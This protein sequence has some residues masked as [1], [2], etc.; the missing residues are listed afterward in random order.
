MFNN[1]F[2]KSSPLNISYNVD[3]NKMEIKGKA[4]RKN[5]ISGMITYDNLILIY[6]YLFQFVHFNLVD[7]EGILKEYY[8]EEV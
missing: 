6:N 4:D 7:E 8:H 5:K 1:F 3:T 2:S